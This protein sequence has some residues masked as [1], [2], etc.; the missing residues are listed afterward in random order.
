MYLQVCP[1]SY[2]IFVSK[3][4]F[5][6]VQRGEEYCVFLWLIYKIIFLIK[7]KKSYT[8]FTDLSLFILLYFFFCERIDFQILNVMFISRNCDSFIC[9]TS[10]FSLLLNLN[11]NYHIYNIC[12]VMVLRLHRLWDLS[13]KCPS[14]IAS[15]RFRWVYC[16]FF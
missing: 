6:F 12:F 1:Y 16:V 8:I 3:V 10:L 13:R 4:A 11:L 14:L 9:Y 5:L 2:T 15:I 7:K